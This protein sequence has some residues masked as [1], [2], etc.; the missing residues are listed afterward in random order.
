MKFIQFLL[1][2]SWLN[3]AI[4]AVAGLVS[5]GVNA[6]LIWLINQAVGQAAVSYSLLYFLGLVTATLLTSTFS[7]FM[8]ISLSQNAIYQLRL[9]L[10]ENILAAPLQHLEMLGSNRLLATLT[11]DVRVLSHTVSVIPNVCTDLAT[12][13]GCLTYLVWLSSDVFIVI[14]AIT[15]IAV[16]CTHSTLG[17]AQQLFAI[18]REEEDHLFKHFQAIATGTKELKLHRSRREE[19]LT[20]ELQGSAATMR[21]KNIAAMRIFALAD[22]LGQFSL[23][24]ILGFTLFILPRFVE[25]SPAMLASYALTTTYLAIPIQNLL[26][27]LPDF[28]RGNVA[29]RK[30]ERMKL[31]LAQEA[32]LDIPETHRITPQNV[33]QHCQI[34]LEQVTYTYHPD[35]DEHGFTLGPVSLSLQPGQVT[36]LVGGNG[37]GKS[38][39]AKL[40][41]G[42][43]PAMT[44]KVSI[45]GVAIADHNREW[46]RQH[47]SAIFSDF[48]LFERCL[49]CDRPNLDHE[50]KHYLKQLQL[51]HKV[52]VRNGVFSTIHLSQGQRKRLALLTAYLEDRPIYLFDE[53]ASDQDPLFRELFYREILVRLKEQG[54]TILVIT[55]DDRYFHLADQIIKLEYGQTESQLSMTVG[56]RG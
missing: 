12:I 21:Q 49:G 34:E 50:A 17:K 39:L 20:E 56:A 8:L 53:W 54:K 44:G 11:D 48:H 43:Y 25:T 7:Q 51:D 33:S 13:V 16:W 1:K 47:F 30:I 23:F 14:F 26:H 46:Y 28:L 10:S 31:A 22:G 3:I 4:A 41:T 45:D 42:L 52:S 27:R 32:E 2:T 38:T 9:R 55:H 15:A 37:S 6:K 40:I 5:G 19:F 18:A 36:Y 24:A 29:L 35:G